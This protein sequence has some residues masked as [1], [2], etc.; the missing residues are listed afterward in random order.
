MSP[1][2]S[3]LSVQ[4]EILSMLSG[5]NPDILLSSVVIYYRTEQSAWTVHCMNSSRKALR[6]EL[7]HVARYVQWFMDWWETPVSHYGRK[8]DTIVRWK[9]SWHDQRHIDKFHG[10]GNVQD[11]A[12]LP[13]SWLPG[14]SGIYLKYLG[15]KVERLG[16]LTILYNERFFSVGRL[17]FFLNIQ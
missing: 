17:S 2:F 1:S 4:T 12:V 9:W 15:I 11:G 6:Q 13:T 5:K 3:H 14:R 8:L 10:L 16:N 7:H